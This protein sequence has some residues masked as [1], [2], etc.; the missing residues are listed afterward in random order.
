M[1]KMHELSLLTQAKE[2]WLIVLKPLMHEKW[3]LSLNFWDDVCQK[4]YCYYIT[5]MSNIRRVEKFKELLKKIL[6]EKESK[7]KGN[8]IKFPTKRQ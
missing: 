1:A 8:V 5:A 4:T 6:K 7:K 3:N 2:E